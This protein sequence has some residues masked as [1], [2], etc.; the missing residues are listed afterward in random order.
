MRPSVVDAMCAAQYIFPGDPMKRLIG[1]T[2]LATAFAA[3]VMAECSYPK[4]PAKIPDGNTAALEDMVAAKK[5]VEAYNKEMEGYLSCI[6]LEGDATIS[7]GGANL[8]EDQK[9]QVAAMYAQKNDAA[10]DELQGIAERLNE[11]IRVYKAK[12]PSK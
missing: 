11:Q 12:H 6:K 5:S 8:T 9:K 7:K 3:P 4:A 2:L 10:V 1:L